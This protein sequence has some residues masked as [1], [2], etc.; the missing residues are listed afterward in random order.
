[1]VA[2]IVLYKQGEPFDMDYYTSRHMPLVD[3]VL[4]PLGMIRAEVHREIVHMD[5][6]PAAHQV[7]AALYFESGEAL[8]AALRNPATAEVTGDVKNFYAEQ[9]E[10]RVAQVL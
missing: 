10:F 6:S 1:M 3:R 7:T 8:R 5:R 9:P 4:K 2:L